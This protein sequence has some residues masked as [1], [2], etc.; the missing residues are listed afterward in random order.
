MSRLAVVTAAAVLSTLTAIPAT[1]AKE[2]HRAH[3]AQRFTSE[4]FR[5]TN[6]AA[7]TVP[8]PPSGYSS[9]YTGGW[10]APAGR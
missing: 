2:H 5:N 3:K 4:Q 1:F 9:M 8:A 10:S 7:A 6:A